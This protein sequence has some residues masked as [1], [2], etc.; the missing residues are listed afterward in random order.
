MR[1][2]RTYGLDLSRSNP[3]SHISEAR[4]RERSGY[5]STSDDML[6]ISDGW[7]MFDPLEEDMMRAMKAPISTDRSSSGTGEPMVLSAS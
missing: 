4:S 6:L 2:S 3:D 7:N 1:S 5:T